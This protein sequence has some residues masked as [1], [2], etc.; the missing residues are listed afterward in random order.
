M[1]SEDEISSKWQQIEPFLI[2]VGFI[3]CVHLPHQW[4]LLILGIDEL[5]HLLTNKLIISID[6]YLDLVRL[7]IVESRV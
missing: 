6:N 3:K 7:A 2:E 1:L 4:I 5:K